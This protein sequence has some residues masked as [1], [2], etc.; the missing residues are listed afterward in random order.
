MT[1]TCTPSMAHAIGESAATTVA[2]TLKALADPFRLRVLSA[3]ATDPR[4]E[5]C[6]C[7]LAELADVSQPTVS[8]HLKVL[9]DT[10]LLASERRGTWVWYRIA[11]EKQHAV[12]S[13]LDA[14]APAALAN[15][16]SETSDAALAKADALVEMDARVTRLA[17]ELADEH[18]DQ[19]RD[20]VIAMV[21]ESFAG[22]ARAARVPQHLIPLTERFARQRLTDLARERKTGVPQVLFVCVQNA[23]RSQ[24][25]A[26]L[27]NQLSDG[28]VVAR[29]AGS[30]PA[31]DVH[32]H[33]R[34]LLTE[35][36]GG[37]RT[38]AA[39]PKPL[40]D[41]AVRAADVVVTMGC[42]D[43]CPII[44]GVRYEDWAVGDPAL[45][46]PEGVAAIRDDIAGRVRTLI[47]SLTND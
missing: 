41:D 27:V 9:K 20:L 28:R 7:D 23:G 47:D 39:F 1:D 13:L 42:G 3:I 32:P 25:A 34:S 36:E 43:V 16:T 35:I 26:A 45:A 40:T 19:S 44:P 10:G 30:A 6:V 22:L 12:S 4:G 29:S 37:Q 21:R 18:A 11:P 46:S 33:V 31:A 5:S 17:E 14:F 2:S 24:L 8:H 15:Q 38:D